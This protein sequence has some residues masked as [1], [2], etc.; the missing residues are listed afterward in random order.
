MRIPCR[1]CATC[2][3]VS[4]CR[5]A[6][7]GSPVVVEDF[8]SGKLDRWTFTDPKAFRISEGDRGKCLELFRKPDYSPKVRSPLGL[9]ILNEPVLSDFVLNVRLRSTVKDYGH[10]DL[11][12]VFG[13]QDPEHFYYVHFGKKADPHSNSIFL[14]NGAPRV[15]IAQTTSKGTNWT[16]G[17][18]G[19]RVR[20]EAASGRIEVYFDDMEKPVMTAVDRTLLTGRIGMGS[21]DDLGMFDELTVETMVLD[22]GK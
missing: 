22:Q 9:A 6:L 1:W 5:A 3:L 18:H 14:V 8:E 11:C 17:W 7:S 16:D 13:Y 15:S 12:V 21:F 4:L 20:R 2:L 10:R 19:V